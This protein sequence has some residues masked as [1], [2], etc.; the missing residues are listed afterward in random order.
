MLMNATL[1]KLFLHTM[2]FLAVEVL[3]PVFLIAKLSLPYT[4][5]AV[6]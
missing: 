2:F 3:L 6:F 4:I 5:L 1:L